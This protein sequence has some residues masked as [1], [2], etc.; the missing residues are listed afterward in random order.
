MRAARPSIAS[1]LRTGSEQRISAFQQVRESG[2]RSLAGADRP[3]DR[4]PHKPSCSDDVL[5]LAMPVVMNL[6]IGCGCCTRTA[7]VQTDCEGKWPIRRELPIS[8]KISVPFK[9]R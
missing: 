9:Y 8:L 7:K 5:F 4:L 6:V 2:A 3:C 1:S